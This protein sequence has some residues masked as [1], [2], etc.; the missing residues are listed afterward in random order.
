MGGTSTDVCHFAG[1][2]ERSFSSK[3][4][5]IRLC[6]PMLEIHTIAAG[7][8]S[9]LTYDGE[10]Y[11][12]GPKSAGAN[13]GPACYRRRGPLSVTDIN[14]ALGKLHPDF[15]PSI[16]GPKQNQT[17][18]IDAAKT[19]FQAVA[20]A[21]HKTIEDTAEGFL[22]IAVDH[23]VRAIKTISTQRGTDLEGYTLAC[24]GGAGGQHVCLVAEKLGITS[25]FI[26]PLAGVL[27]AYGM[28]L[29]DISKHVQKTVNLPIKDAIFAHNIAEELAQSGRRKS[30]ST[31]G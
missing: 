17:L 4:A 28:G 27:S 9:I 3:I 16:F 25:I 5:G 24:F 12:V 18:D 11:Q 15:F 1:Q 13:P 30:H 7:G 8:G 29:A 22:S 26:H 2:Y 21:S 10:R 19:A 14:A 23:M 20:K 31:R 6:A